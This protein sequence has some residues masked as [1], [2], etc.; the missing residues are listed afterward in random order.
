MRA[1]VAS[2]ICVALT[3][4]AATAA[5]TEA[6][7][8][9][10]KSPAAVSSMEDRRRLGIVRQREFV[11]QRRVAQDQT[12]IERD[13]VVPGRIESETERLRA[14]RNERVAGISRLRLGVCASGS[15]ALGVRGFRLTDGFAFHAF[16]TGRNSS[17]KWHATC[18]GPKRRSFGIVILHI[19]ALSGQRPWKRQ[20]FGSGSIGLRGSPVSRNRPPP[21]SCK[22][23]TAATRAWV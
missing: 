20:T 17:A 11:D 22:R 9:Q 4:P 8:S 1:S 19:A 23:G 18:R 5:A 15:R 6:A 7:E 2:M 12:Q 14:C 13:A 3:R 10:A 21:L 16:G